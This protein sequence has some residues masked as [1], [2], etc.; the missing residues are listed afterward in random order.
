M[1]CTFQLQCNFS[2]LD[3][4]QD[5]YKFSDKMSNGK[6]FNLDNHLVITMKNVTYIYL[7]A[8]VHA[9]SID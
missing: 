9:P 8:S 6:V 3:T 7:L 1:E 2:N 5:I 4:T